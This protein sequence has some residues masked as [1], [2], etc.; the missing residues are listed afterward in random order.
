MFRSLLPLL[1]SLS[2]IA[3][4]VG[5]AVLVSVWFFNSVHILTIVFGAS[6][7]GIVVDYSL[8]YFYHFLAGQKGKA[9]R[10]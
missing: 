9:V 1:L 8:H 10:I 5:S 2:S 3:I 7:I 6:L 4:G